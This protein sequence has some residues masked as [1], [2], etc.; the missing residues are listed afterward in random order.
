MKSLKCLLR[1]HGPRYDVQVINTTP[2]PCFSFGL[3]RGSISIEMKMFC[4][5][6]K[7]EIVF[8][9]SLVIPM[10]K[11]VGVKTPWW[12]RIWRYDPIWD[13]AYFA[14]IPLNWILRRFWNLYCYSCRFRPNWLEK[15]MKQAR[16]QGYEKGREHERCYFQRRLMQLENEKAL[17][18]RVRSRH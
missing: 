10:E 16:N 2:K 5:R 7:T 15:Q 4:R 11:M 3:L 13:M 6:C 17:L 8:P 12:A 14:P 1:I 9:K 18:K